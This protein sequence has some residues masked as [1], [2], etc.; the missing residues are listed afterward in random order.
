MPGL[1]RYPRP[2]FGRSVLS[3]RG[4]AA[5]C[6]TFA[7]EAEHRVMSPMQVSTSKESKMKRKP[8]LVMVLVLMFG[9]A[10]V[11]TGYAQALAG[12]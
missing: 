2:R 11:I 3:G 1:I 9:V 6:A 7:T 5:F 4:K 8:D 12:N 10:V